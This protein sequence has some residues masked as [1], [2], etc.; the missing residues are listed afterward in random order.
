[1]T[2]PPLDSLERLDRVLDSLGPVMVAVSGGID[3]LTLMA[4]AHRRGPGLARA[5]HASSPAVPAAALER[6][7][8]IAARQQWALDI[9]DAG[10]LRDPDYRRNPLDRCYFC[11]SNLYRALEHL[12]CRTG[13]VVVSG[14]NVDDLSD[15]RPGLEAARQ[16][17]VRHPFI[18][19]A[20]GKAGIRRLAR[21]LGLGDL[22][23]LPA[24]PCLSSRVETGIAIDA[25][26]LA[27]IDRAET[28]V[29]HALGAHVVRC[30]IRPDTCTIELGDDTMWPVDTLDAVAVT[31]AGILRDAGS[32]RPVTFARYHMG[33]AFVG[34]PGPR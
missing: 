26:L 8:A 19:A 1:M 4:A 29:R 33:S 14:A 22:A 25:R 15:F 16:K 18:E 28:A 21:T 23:D 11:K 31:V 3:S 27:A 30:R 6:L 32:A 20:I 9:V 24:S 12:A 34:A 2:A 17:G 7:Q 10:E 13:I 5:A